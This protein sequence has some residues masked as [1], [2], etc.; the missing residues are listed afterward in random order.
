MEN[1]LFELRQEEVR[2]KTRNIERKIANVTIDNERP[3]PP[4]Q[5]TTESSLNNTKIVTE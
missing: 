1:A 4:Q 3:Q 5:Q 2:T